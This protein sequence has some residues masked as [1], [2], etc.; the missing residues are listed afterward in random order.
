MKTNQTNLPESKELKYIF[1][2]ETNYF[3]Q[4]TATNLSKGKRKT[5]LSCFSFQITKE[6]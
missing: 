4:Q 2:P 3:E 5:V 6:N 1:N